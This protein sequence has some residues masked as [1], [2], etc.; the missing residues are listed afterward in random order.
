MSLRLRPDGVLDPE[1][2]YPNPFTG[3]P[4]NKI[5]KEQ[6]TKMVDGVNKGWAGL[7]TFEDR[8][9]ILRRI[10][11]YQFI[12]L[13]ATTGVG[14]TVIVPK[15]MAHYFGYEK[16]IICTTP[17]TSTTIGAGDWAAKCMDVP[18]E[19]K[20]PVTGETKK[21]EKDFYVGIR[22]GA[23]KEKD[24][25]ATKLLFATDG[26]IKSIMMKT[27]PNLDGYY[28]ILIDE[29]HER[30]V[31]ID[32]LLGLIVDLCKRRP[33]FRVIIMSATVNEEVFIQYFNRLG[34]GHKF[35]LYNPEGVKTTFKLET[36]Y[37][38]KPVTPMKVVEE[39]Q[40][41]INA[42][43]Q[44]AAEMDKLM[45]PGNVG[46]KGRFFKYGRDI[47]G[48]L[49][50]ENECMKVK[51]TIDRN[52]AEGKYKYHPYT[53]VL[54]RNTDKLT[55]D[56][57]KDDKGMSLIPA[58]GQKYDLKVIIS[59][60]VAESSTTFGE[61]LA[62]VIDGGM[63]NYV[64]FD[65]V[66]YGTKQ[67]KDLTAQANIKQRC[68]RTA[69]IND[70]ICY[71]VYSKKQWDALVGFP[72]PEI[73]HSDI[74]EQ[75][76]SLILLPHIG[77]INKL[78]E[79]VGNMVE[80]PQNYKEGLKVGLRNLLDYDYVD[81]YGR[82]TA[83]GV[84]CSSFGKAGS[85]IARL[86]IMGYYLGILKEVLFLGA[87]LNNCAS[88]TDMFFAPKGKE[89]DPEVVAQF[90][91]IL[92]EFTHPA[93][94]HLTMVN[95]YLQWVEQPEYIKPYWEKQ[96]IIKRSKMEAIT[97]SI[98]ELAQTALGN[99]KKMQTLNL[100]KVY[101]TGGGQEGGG[102]AQFPTNSAGDMYI[103]AFG[104]DEFSEMAKSIRANI[105][106]V[107][108]T[109]LQSGGS[110]DS[111]SDSGLDTRVWLDTR[112]EAIGGQLGCGDAMAQHLGVKRCINQ[113]RANCPLVG[114]GSQSSDSNPLVGGGASFGRGRGRGRGGPSRG[115]GR[116]GPPMNPEERERQRL[117]K[118]AQQY[119]ETKLKEYI[120]APDMNLRGLF[121]NTAETPVDIGDVYKLS[122]AERIMI[123]LYFAYHT[124]LG[125][126]DSDPSGTSNNYYLKYSPLKG[127]LKD[128]SLQETLKFRPNFVIY[129]TFAIS[130]MG[131]KLSIVSQM[132]HSVLDKFKTAK[133][134]IIPGAKRGS[135]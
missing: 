28:G 106:S 133:T 3:E 43:L 6:S 58:D 1:G 105:N 89:E 134:K 65:A 46:D 30:S 17:R 2:R 68:G 108:S 5:Y 37:S 48:F 66:N 50:S 82:P 69:R 118:E 7:K 27:N 99:I 55:S 90:V 11:N 39:V 129:N 112:E 41:K 103:P 54:T 45:G 96:Y 98:K 94:D 15:L 128:S 42:I 88:Y 102:V 130:D 29:A 116:G 61:P 114:G 92:G 26:T 81:I 63:A 62:W 110:G 4:Y 125:I 49:T 126:Y 19:W 111:I 135:D 77:D 36:I 34:M 20:D 56:I 72:D 97:E 124:Q 75:L 59:T 93:G 115:R 122:L 22:Y 121:A 24:D 107:P 100:I 67:F 14:K 53:I 40:N 79:F 13:I 91:K 85:Y 10:H 74:T 38:P 101:Q 71:K 83:L 18:F 70:G 23:E 76:L 84:M 120:N 44:D 60:P 78:L 8:F 80:P 9:D 86:I 119:R 25:K 51:Q 32:I 47:L 117:V 87:I 12:L 57:A 64:W 21:R 31:N 113:L 104:T 109:P 33:E 132:P 73:M 35:N 131:N 16:A 127:S 52:W 123:A 95:L